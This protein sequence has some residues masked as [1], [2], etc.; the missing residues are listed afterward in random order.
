LGAADGPVKSAIFGL[1]AARFYKLNLRADYHEDGMGKMRA[2]YLGDP[3]QRSN[4][5]YGYIAHG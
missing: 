1:N 3:P 2:A 4:A 5:T